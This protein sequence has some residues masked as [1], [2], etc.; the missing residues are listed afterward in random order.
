MEPICWIGDGL[1]KFSNKDMHVTVF[2]SFFIF[3]LQNIHLSKTCMNFVELPQDH[4]CRL[5]QEILV[6]YGRI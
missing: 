5:K 4:N 6:F 3:W 1:V 2:F